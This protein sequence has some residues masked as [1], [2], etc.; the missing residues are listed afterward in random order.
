M[1]WVMIYKTTHVRVFPWY[2]K[3]YFVGTLQAKK[4]EKQI[5]WNRKGG[6]MDEAEGTTMI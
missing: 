5:K 2:K 3:E 4:N 6:Q 1:L